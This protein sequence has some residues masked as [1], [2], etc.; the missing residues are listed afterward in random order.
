MLLFFHVCHVPVIH[1]WHLHHK[2]AHILLS[3]K[4]KSTAASLDVFLSVLFAAEIG[5]EAQIRFLKAKVRVM[6]EELDKLAHDV[7][8]KV[9]W[10]V[11]AVFP[12]SKNLLPVCKNTMCDNN[13][14]LCLRV[15]KCGFC[16]SG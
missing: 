4:F 2:I 7:S 9:C 10:S 16:P 13:Q 14:F 5:S 6:Q 8:K 1:S 12:V 11:A 3:L 15:E